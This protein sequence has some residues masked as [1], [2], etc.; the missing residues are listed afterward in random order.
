[1]VL[2]ETI[3]V[4]VLQPESNREVQV[5]E[6]TDVNKDGILHNGFELVLYGDLRDVYNDKYHAFLYNRNEILVQ[7]PSINHSFLYESDKLMAKMREANVYCAR[8]QE[9]HD[10]A[11]NKILKNDNRQKKRLLL[12][13]PS[14]FEL[15]NTIY[16]PQ[17]TDG[18]IESEFVPFGSAFDINGKKYTT[19]VARI[20]W[21][22]S[23]VETDKREVKASSKDSCCQAFSKTRKYANVIVVLVT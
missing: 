6:F 11:R 16:S 20:S 14:D 3:D 8:T 21:K 4:N 1:M 10:V 7:M 13:F 19:T 2:T 22:V 15:S 5:F 9:S 12:S 18:E 17:S 23:I